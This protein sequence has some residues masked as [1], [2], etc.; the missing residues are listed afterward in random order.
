[1]L[2]NISQNVFRALHDI[3]V[4]I[5]QG[6]NSTRRR[7][8]ITPA[9]MRDVLSD[10]VLSAIDFHCQLQFFAIEVEDVWLDRKL[11]PEFLIVHAAVAQH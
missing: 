3:V 8:S 9:V 10:I 11:T 2:P 6:C 1:M 5:T 4:P 7:E